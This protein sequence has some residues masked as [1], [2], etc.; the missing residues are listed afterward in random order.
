MPGLKTS[1]PLT[2]SLAKVIIFSKP[3]KDIVKFTTYTRL[4]A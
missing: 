4:M 2:G 3:I 1:L